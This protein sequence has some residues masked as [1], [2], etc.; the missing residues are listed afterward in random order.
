MSLPNNN[1]LSHREVLPRTFEHRLG[2]A[3]TASRRFSLTLVEPV[4][5]QDLL[6]TINIKHGDSHPEFPYLFCLTGRISEPDNQH[7]EIEYEYGVPQEAEGPL[8]VSGGG[9][10]GGGGGLPVGGTLTFYPHPLNQRDVVSFSGSAANVPQTYHFPDPTDTTKFET[11]RN[12]A[13]DRI[14]GVEATVGEMRCKITGNRSSFDTMQAASV[15]GCVNDAPWAGFGQGTWQCLGISASPAKEYVG[16]PYGTVAFWKIE[17]DLAWRR[18]GWSPKLLQAGYYCYR[19][20]KKQR[21]VVWD[22]VL[23]LWVPS[24]GEM[25]LATD[26][27][28]LD[29]SVVGAAG[30]TK[31]Y[32][33]HPAIDFTAAFGNLTNSNYP[34]PPGP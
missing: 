16:N 2:G 15:I 21:C 34:V 19:N 31:T 24:S 27:R 26:G 4:Q 13:G 14:R 30:H 28:Q 1:I 5:H 3:P 33:V 25:L 11:I 9:A 10:G 29:P 18:Q 8:P 7:A 17:V 23:N 20:G 12:T 6:D 22:D 32:N